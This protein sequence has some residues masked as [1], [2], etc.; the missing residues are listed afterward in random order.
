MMPESAADIKQRFDQARA[1][2]GF[3][4]S[5]VWIGAHQGPAFSRA[6]TIDEL[7]AILNAAYIEEALVSHFASVNYDPWEGNRMLLDAVEGREG[8]W[9]AIVLTADGPRGCGVGD[10]LQRALVR[11]ARAVRMFPKSQSF[12]IQEW[13]SGPLL[14]ILEQHKLPLILHHSELDWTEI[15]SLCLVHPSLPVIVEGTG[16]KILYDNRFF[17][18]LLRDC[19]N[20]HLENC[21]L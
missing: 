18:Q 19:A 3:F 20:L 21:A 14:R 10:Y 15:R 11:K 7:H 6:E 13:Q 8:L 1:A 2:A 16:K 12:S 5:N 4:D 9:A 17:Y